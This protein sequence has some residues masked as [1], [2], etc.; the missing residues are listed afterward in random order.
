[1][2]I[3]EVIGAS[4]FEPPSS[5]SRTTNYINLPRSVSWRHLRSPT[6]GQVPH[7]C[8]FWSESLIH[9]GHGRSSPGCSGSLCL[10]EYPL[11]QNLFGFEAHPA[12]QKRPGQASP[13]LRCQ[14]SSEAGVCNSTKAKLWDQMGHNEL[15]ESNASDSWV[16][17]SKAVS[18]LRRSAV[19]EP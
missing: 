2:D 14:Q 19:L 15:E 16:G 10:L 9:S 7:R 6:K 12:G 13:V 1:V 5:W 4:G 17:S 11:R 8:R 18:S 3:L